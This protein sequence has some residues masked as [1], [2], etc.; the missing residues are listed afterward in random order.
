MF[1]RILLKWNLLLK[2]DYIST[3]MQKENAKFIRKVPKLIV[4]TTIAQASD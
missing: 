4:F 1:A 2:T 3:T